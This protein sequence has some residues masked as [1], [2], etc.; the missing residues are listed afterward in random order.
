MCECN[1]GHWVRYEGL[2]KRWVDYV[3]DIHWA[4]SNCGY[5]PYEGA[6]YDRQNHLSNFCPNCGKKMEYYE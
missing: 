3:Y 6:D 5:Q 4:C 1:K 2:I